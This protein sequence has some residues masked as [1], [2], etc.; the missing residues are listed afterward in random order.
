MQTVRR[1]LRSA[2]ARSRRPRHL[3][4]LLALLLGGALQI[5]GTASMGV[6]QIR[7]GYFWDPVRAGPFVARGFAYQT[8]NP[9]VGANQSLPQIDYDLREFRKLRANSVRC[10][11]TWGE[12]QKGETVYDWSRSDHLVR[13]AESLGLR[14]FV[15]IGFQYPPAWVPIAYRGVNDRYTTTNDPLGVA[16]NELSEVLNYEHPE[17]RRLYSNHVA[18]VTGRYRGNPAIG[19]WILGNEYAYYDLWEDPVAYS[20]HRFIGYDPISQERFR[21]YLRNLYGDDIRALNSKW[22]SDYPGFDAVEMPRPYPPDRRSPGYH[23]LIQW[24]KRSIADFVAVGALAA[25]RADPDHLRTYS[26]VGAVFSNVDANHTCEDART[27]V[28][29]CAEVGA[30]LHF[31]SVNNYPW[32]AAGSEL[33]S[34]D[35]GVG[36]FHSELGLP[37]MVSETGLTSTETLWPTERPG[38]RQA[39]AAPGVLWESL[40]SGA[41]GVHWF[42]WS[43]RNQYT[44][45]Y[46]ARER[47][48]GIVTE[49]RKW[50]GPVY[51]GLARAFAR[52][53]NVRLDWLLWGSAH[54]AP[55]IQFLWSA[56]SDMVWPR[57]NQ[58]NCMIWGALRR[59]GYQPGILDDAGFARGDFARAPALLLSRAYQLEA[60]QLNRLQRDVIPLGIHIHAQA[61]L[62]GQFDAYHRANT[63][64]AEVLES[65]FGL[66][67][68]QATPGLDGCVTNIVVAGLNLRG[69]STLGVLTPGYQRRFNTWKIWHGTRAGS[70]RIILTHTGRDEARPPTPALVVKEHGPGR[71]RTAIDT[72]AQGDIYANDNPSKWEL[73]RTRRELLGAVYRDHF[74]IR[75]GIELSGPQ[76]HLVLPD[77]RRCRNGSVLL[78]LL[79]ESTN[80]ATVTVHAPALLAGRRTEDLLRGG[81]LTNSGSGSLTVS[82]PGD[83]LVLLYA[84]DHAPH[85]D[86]SLVNASVDK[87]WF[88]DPPRLVWPQ[89][90]PHPVG[91][92]YDASTRDLRLVVTLEQTVPQFRVV[93]VCEVGGV[94]GRGSVQVPLVLPDADP[95]DAGLVATRDGG[96]YLLAARVMQGDREISRSTQPVFVGWGVRPA[97]PLPAP[98][99]A[100]HT[101]QVDVRWDDLP[102]TVPGDPTPLGRTALWDSAEVLQQWYRVVLELA[103]GGQQVAGD[104]HLTRDGEGRHTFSVAVPAGLPGPFTWRLRLEAAPEVASHDIEESYEG[105]ARGARWPDALDTDFLSPWSSYQYHSPGDESLWQNEGVHLT[106]SHGSQSAF[107]VV[108]NP[109]AQ[110]YS[111]FGLR[112]TFPIDWALPENPQAWSRYACGFDFKESRNLDH[113]LELQLVDAEGG[114]LTC[115]PE[116]RTTPAGWSTVSATLD[117]FAVAGPGGFDPRRIRAFAANVQMWVAPAQYVGAF[118]QLW[119]SGPDLMVRPG[120]EVSTYSSENDSA[121]VLAIVPD[122]RSVV[123]SW[124]G[125]GQL[126]QAPAVGG[127]WQDVVGA[128]SPVRL[129]AGEGNLYLRLRGR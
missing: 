54:P 92:G 24:R 27:I 7:D 21:N 97:A 34:A 23:D 42:H 64:W 31:W 19:A 122:G 4:C 9:P 47:G 112:Y 104:S 38:A 70:G 6:L 60:D 85:G 107:L 84:Y 118:D 16:T 103:S 15:L 108:T 20:V 52:M 50:K 35:F 67:V 94:E 43:D 87:V 93:A 126:Q 102:S 106:G 125:N 101:Y 65:V 124:Y 8:W 74:G 13:L 39:T 116:P 25:Q 44:P 5:K 37:V 61:D 2:G 12:M 127:P 51:D 18:A 89:L 79:N 109:P 76:A 78:S 55:D 110:D 41:V 62:P 14:L 111:G 77:Y 72:F 56:Q 69:V 98:V 45:S 105:R 75:P 3:A 80:T 128:Q 96:E 10:E 46:F 71:G 33:R 121:G 83:D 115:L 57:A 32:P 11:F 30:P 100:G 73:Y 86:A 1:F 17:A 26:M 68:R 53:E 29:R 90:A 40:I 22:G 48:F 91:I 66:D 28:A 117:Q 82:I 88:E 119:F 123:V 129:P 113:V 36:R 114:R 99:E 81:I 95:N 63:N 120:T 58:E 59:L 49:T